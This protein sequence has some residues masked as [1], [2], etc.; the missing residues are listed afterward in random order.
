MTEQL[1]ATRAAPFAGR[2]LREK[3]LRMVGAGQ[4]YDRLARLSSSL[5][6]QRAISARLEH[7]VQALRGDLQNERRLLHTERVEAGAREEQLHARLTADSDLL[8]VAQKR[9][10][11]VEYLA[12]DHRLIELDYPAKPRTR[13]GWGKPTEPLLTKLIGDGNPRYAERITSFLPLVEKMAEIPGETSAPAEP[14]WVNPWIPASDAVSIYAQLVLRDPPTYL[15][16]GSGTST[17]FARRA[18]KDF[19]LR[20]KIISIDPFPRAEINAICDEVIR[21]P[22]QKVSASTFSNLTGED[23]LFFDGSHRALPDSDVTVFFT[24]ILP[25]LPA[26]L[27]TGIHDTFL[28]ADYPPFWGE[29]FYSEQYLLA[30]WLLA[31]SKLRIELPVFYCGLLPELHGILNPLWT[32]PSLAGAQ[33]EGG[34]FWITT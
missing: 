26:G 15:E 25:T 13:H 21:V 9:V 4:L 20:T 17:K 10:A 33:L 5:H 2:G 19:G 12:A 28:P 32:K 27:L 23:M 3:V 7:E 22:L 30:C 18:I 24:E 8:R 14:H 29:R 16:I 34:A 31:G 1:R 6:E 11:D